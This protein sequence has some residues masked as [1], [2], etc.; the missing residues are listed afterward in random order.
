MPIRRAILM[1]VEDTVQQLHHNTDV[2]E[3][4]R[5]SQKDRR[6]RYTIHR[7]DMVGKNLRSELY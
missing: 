3:I 1:E 6:P 7:R 4:A 5:T 2:L